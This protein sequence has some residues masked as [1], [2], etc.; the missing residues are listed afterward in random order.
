MN[1]IYKSFLKSKYQLSQKSVHRIVFPHKVRLVD[2][3]PESKMK[4]N[5]SM[6]KKKKEKSAG[7]IIS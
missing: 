4:N 5:Q 7:H 3:T 6:K 1:K 2:P